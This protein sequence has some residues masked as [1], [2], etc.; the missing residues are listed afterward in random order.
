VHALDSDVSALSVDDAIDAV[1]AG[2]AENFD[3]IYSAQCQTAAQ[4][5]QFLSAAMRQFLVLRTLRTQVDEGRNAA[6]AVAAARPPV[7]FTR[8]NLV[9]RVLGKLSSRDVEDILR[10]LYDCVL[11][12]RREPLLAVASTRQAFLAIA[13]RVARA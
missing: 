8:R 9:E 12:T 1:I 5:F 11:L 7:F 10:R 4:T 13:V 6:G 3:A 2:R